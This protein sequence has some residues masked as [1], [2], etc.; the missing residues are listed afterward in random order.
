MLTRRAVLMLTLVIAASSGSYAKTGDGEAYTGRVLEIVDGNTLKVVDQFQQ[1]HNIR[2][3]GIDAPETEQ[4]FGTKA[5]EALFAKV[6]GKE[7]DVQVIDM[8]R[9]GHEIVYVYAGAKIPINPD[10]VREGFA[11]RNPQ[12]DK[13]SRVARAEGVFTAA[14]KDAREHKR[15]LWADPHPIPPWEFR[16]AKREGRKVE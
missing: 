7:I 12:Y 1:Q 5:R 9:F 15:G 14:E 2:L 10:L 8:D 4:A 16:R 6:H 3:A 13:R 11:W